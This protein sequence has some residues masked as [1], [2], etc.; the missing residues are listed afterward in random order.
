MAST[1]CVQEHHSPFRHLFSWWLG[2]RAERAAEIRLVDVDDLDAY[3]LQDI[4]IEPG[5]S[6]YPA[7]GM[8]CDHTRY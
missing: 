5:S 6:R 4:G 3:L 2:G 1:I 8:R 7:F